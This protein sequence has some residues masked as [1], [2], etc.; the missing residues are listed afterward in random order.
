M[1][2]ERNQQLGERHQKQGMKTPSIV[3]TVI[4]SS[5]S[6]TYSI[7]RGEF[8][9]KG[10]QRGN[11]AVF[12]MAVKDSLFPRM[13]FFQGTNAS[14]DFSMETRSICGYL[15]VCCGVSYADA[16]QWWDNHPMM[17]KNIHTDC[18]NNKIK[19]IKQ[20]LNGK[21]RY[22][23]LMIYQTPCILLTLLLLKSLD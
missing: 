4:S 2:T 14:L 5:Q 20:Q 13:K 17:L 19:M 23:Q 3:E 1:A 7:G 18:R 16:S 12:S 10:G 6:L 9:K 22:S 15:R 11:A 8:G 21:T